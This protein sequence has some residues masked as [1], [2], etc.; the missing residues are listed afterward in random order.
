MA[1]IY[2]SDEQHLISGGLDQTMGCWEIATGQCVQVLKG[3]TG[4]VSTMV[5]QPIALACD[6]A[7]QA[8]ANAPEAVLPRSTSSLFSGSFDET[9]K[10]WSLEPYR[11]CQ[12]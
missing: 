5:C 8:D 4:L 7:S 12:L 6:A 2:S 1:V 3:Q 9:I 10:R 11:A